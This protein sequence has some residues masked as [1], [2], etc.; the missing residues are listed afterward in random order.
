MLW[1]L[2]RLHVES[3]AAKLLLGDPTWRDLTA[4]TSY[5]ETAPLPTW[6]GW[7]GHQLPRAVHRACGAATYLVELG[8]PLLFWGSPALRAGAFVAVVGFQVVILAT[9]NYAF[10]NHLTAALALFLLDDAQLARAAA[11]VGLRLDPP[12]AP[13]ASRAR[14]ACL[15]AIV[16]VLVPLSLLPF[17]RFV[18]G[19]RGVARA[20]HP[21]RAAM[22]PWRSLNAYHLFA[23]MTLVRR[24]VVIEGSA[25]GVTWQPYEFRHKPGDPR[26][27]PRFVAPH[28]PRVDFQLWFLLLGRGREE[29]YFR[30][31][32]VR[33]LTEPRVVAPL[34][35]RDPFAET[36]PRFLRLAFYRYRFTDLAT[37]RAAGTWWQRELLGHSRPLT[38][39]DVGGLS[40]R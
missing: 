31:L 21:V 14:T 18:P 28:Q 22:E 16:V 11:A 15:A 33:L 5:Y 10:F 35:A 17:L 29:P 3:G 25:D 32:L 37:R 19:T 40:P 20:L 4:L 24:E 7:W 39:Q 6:I 1:L 34:F 30:T 38:A 27:P 13:A 2:F 12:A 8:V 26:R 36:P 9:A 23:Q